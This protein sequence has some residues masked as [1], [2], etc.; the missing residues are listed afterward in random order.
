M[1]DSSG[2]EWSDNDTAAP[3]AHRTCKFWA[4]PLRKLLV[5]SVSTLL[6]PKQLLDLHTHKA[7]DLPSRCNG[8]ATVYKRVYEALDCDPMLYRNKTTGEPCKP[9][10][11]AIRKAGRRWCERWWHDD[12]LTNKP[13]HEV[14][15]KDT[16]L[17]QSILK[18]MLAILSEGFVINQ[19]EVDEQDAALERGDLQPDEA[20]FE[21]ERT[22]VFFDLK[23]A[24]AVSPQFA[25]L[26]TQ[27]AE[28]GITSQDGMWRKLKE[29]SVQLGYPMYSGIASTKKERDEEVTLVRTR[30]CFLLCKSCACVS[31]ATA[32]CG[33]WHLLSC[34]SCA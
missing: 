14:G 21:L 29:M 13:A 5:S 8:W 33:M 31:V 26:T 12:S 22:S 30:S 15:W 20:D 25:A 11:Q 4:R 19:E 28:T 32:D 27:L 6:T 34:A 9:S 17:R 23:H 18:Q 16:E 2:D 24:K 3:A 10:E 7:N 1:A